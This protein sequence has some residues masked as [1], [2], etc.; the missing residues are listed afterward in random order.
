MDYLCYENKT[1][2]INGILA[3]QILPE[4]IL[5][6]TFSAQS[7]ASFL[8]CTDDAMTYLITRK[9]TVLHFDLCL[10]SKYFSNVLLFKGITVTCLFFS[11]FLRL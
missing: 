10:A 2:K 8:D 4:I 7:N 3:S 6:L 5:A 9:I 11:F 1:L